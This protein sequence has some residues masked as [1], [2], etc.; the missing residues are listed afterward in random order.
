MWPA[1]VILVDVVVVLHI[2]PPPTGPA[3]VG[4][5]PAHVI[6]ARSG[7]EGHTPR[8]RIRGAARRAEVRPGVTQIVTI[9]AAGVVVGS[10][11]LV[12]KEQGVGGARAARHR[13]EGYPR[14]IW[15]RGV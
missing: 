2:T 6:V 7:H 13:T 4:V 1:H 15:T 8:P 9:G 14:R 12:R 10:H 11:N 5:G 3:A